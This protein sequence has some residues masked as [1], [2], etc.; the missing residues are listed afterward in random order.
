MATTT[1]EISNAPIG[2]RERYTSAIN[3][4]SMKV[5]T[6]RRSAGD[7]IVA[8]AWSKRDLG[9]A[10]QRLQGEWD[11]QS[12]KPPLDAEAIERIAGEYTREPSTSPHAGLVRQ[13]VKDGKGDIIGVEYVLPLM[14]ARKHAREWREHEQRL[15]FQRLKTL[16]EVRRQLVEWLDSEGAEHTVAAVLWWW[17][18]PTC[19]ACE[20]R[21]FRVAEGTG[22]TTGR[23]CPRCTRQNRTPGEEQIPHAGRGK[24]LANY[25]TQC[26]GEAGGET[27]KKLR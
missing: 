5:A 15:V 13:D 22:H 10:L 9:I 20:G 4:S 27:G 16:P 6:D 19:K 17:L 7:V 25:I 26:V 11:S 18:N 2:T 24:A 21:Q 12:L 3:Q 1:E 23:A 14:L 8:A